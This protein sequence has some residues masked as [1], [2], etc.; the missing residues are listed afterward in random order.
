M[1]VWSG[2]G[3]YTATL[4][5]IELRDKEYRPVEA[6]RGPGYLIPTM[7]GRGRVGRFLKTIQ[8]L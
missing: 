5:D 4:M 7:Q 3:R 2:G 6:I 1:H 8:A